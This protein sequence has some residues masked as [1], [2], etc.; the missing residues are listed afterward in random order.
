MQLGT[1]IKSRRENIGLTQKQL[2]KEVGVTDVT[3]SRYETGERE[4]GWWQFLKI[5]KVLSMNP[6]DFMEGEKEWERLNLEDL[7]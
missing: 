7:E 1:H 2:A 5:C 6:M 3:I 4:P